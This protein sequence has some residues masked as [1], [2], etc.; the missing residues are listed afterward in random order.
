MGSA[1]CTSSG[2]TAMKLNRRVTIKQQSTTRDALG[3]PLTVWSEVAT[4]WSNILHPR[5]AE[6][7]RGDRDVSI[8]QASIRIR[9]RTDV[10]AAMR[11]YYGSL[12]Y[13]IKAVLRDEV[14]RINVD[15]VCE[16][17]NG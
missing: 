2:K 14:S 17:I 15:L 3:Q 8:V 12:V 16:L 4:V 6:V 9:Y 11:V 10:T 1:C 7:I 5:G 13:E